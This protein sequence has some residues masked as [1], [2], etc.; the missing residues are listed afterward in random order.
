MAI[1]KTP[2]TDQPIEYPTWFEH[3]RYMF[4][5]DD[6]DHMHRHR[7][8]FPG[9]PDIDLS[10]YVT[11]KK[12]WSRIWASVDEGLMPKDRDPWPEAWVQTFVNWKTK[13]NFKKGVPII[14]PGEQFDS[15]PGRIRKDIETMPEKEWAVKE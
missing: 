14:I 2:P 13:N 6:I 11:V 4:T 8:H 7:E 12:Q 1:S 5:D 15:A 3:I 10:D 9:A